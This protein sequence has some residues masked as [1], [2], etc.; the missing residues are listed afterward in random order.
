MVD[1]LV[2]HR[3]VLKHSFTPSKRSVPNSD[4]LGREVSVRIVSNLLSVVCCLFLPLLPAD[5]QPPLASVVHSSITSA[6][7]VI[8][9]PVLIDRAVSLPCCHD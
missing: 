1:C 4:A 5:L 6:G 9:E 3:F 2:I 8:S 7:V